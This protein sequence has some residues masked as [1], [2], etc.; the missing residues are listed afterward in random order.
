MRF[1]RS[2]EALSIAVCGIISDEALR[3]A[4]SLMSYYSVTLRKK[5]ALIEVVNEKGTK[6]RLSDLVTQDVILTEGILGFRRKGVEIFPALYLG[7]AERIRERGYEVV[8]FFYREMEGES[9]IGFRECER[10]FYLGSMVSYERKEFLEKVE[11]YGSKRRWIQKGD[12]VTFD[13]TRELRK[14]FEEE[15]GFTLQAAPYIK[16]PDLLTYEDA[17]EI[18]AFLATEGKKKKRK[19]KMNYG[20]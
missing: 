2:K 17:K 13:N 3:L 11:E 18:R 14:A 9:H 4:M 19:I 5:V 10:R 12:L 20:K 15:Y 6:S 8:I 1:L 7:E 16:N